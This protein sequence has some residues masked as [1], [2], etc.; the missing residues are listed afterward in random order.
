MLSRKVPM[1]GVVTRLHPC[2]HVRTVPPVRLYS[3]IQ[4]GLQD[5]L[6]ASV[7]HLAIVSHAVSPSSV[8][9]Y[10]FVR[11]AVVFHG[12]V[13]PPA[14]ASSAYAPLAQCD[15]GVVVPRPTERAPFDALLSVPRWLLEVR[16]S[17]FGYHLGVHP[18]LP[19][20]VLPDQPNLP[21][22]T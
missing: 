2:Q 9:Q 4:V 19:D 7:V 12:P 5:V 22:F 8:C 20:Q 10:V 11:V 14:P 18:N 13:A 3:R 15:L 6:G 16:S 21:S 17:L 1:S